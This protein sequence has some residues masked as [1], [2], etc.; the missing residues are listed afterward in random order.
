MLQTR[1]G[2]SLV[3]WGENKAKD[4]SLADEEK[5]ATSAEV[6]SSG[7]EV[8]SGEDEDI[9]GVGLGQIEVSNREV[10]RSTNMEIYKTLS[11]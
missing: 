10:F 1:N 2:T 11:W 8:S 6:E 3:K 4:V 9:D 5:F 7:L